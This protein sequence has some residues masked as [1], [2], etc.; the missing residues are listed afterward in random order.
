MNAPASLPNSSRS[1]RVDGIAALDEDRSVLLSWV[2]LSPEGNEK[3]ARAFADPILQES[4]TRIA[5][6]TTLAGEDR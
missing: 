6:A 4:C 1:S 3:L 5:V 2:H